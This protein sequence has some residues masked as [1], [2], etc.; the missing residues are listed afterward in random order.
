MILDM[1]SPGQ[2]VPHEI[3]VVIEIPAHSSPIKYEMDKKSG[4]MFVDRFSNAAMF[5]PCNYG[6]VPHSLSEDGDPV[7]MLVA[8]PL[9]VM[10][11]AVISCRPIGMLKMSDEAGPDAKVLAVPAKGIYAP[12]DAI[13]NVD[14]LPSGLK[15][16]ITHFFEQYK[17][18]EP[19]KWVKVEGWTGTQDAQRE[20][21][22]SITRY[23][24]RHK[25]PHTIEYSLRKSA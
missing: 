6:F 17:M 2:N 5:Y 16:Q 12:Y 14:D 22:R 9:P 18:L 8:T 25:A 4:A 23:E 10:S 11:G 13:Q 15:H 1:L 24:H 19:N 21:L 7:D 3:N 20:I